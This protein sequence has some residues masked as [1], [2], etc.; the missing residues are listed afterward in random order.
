MLGAAYCSCGADLAGYP[1]WEA[2]T[3]LDP[4]W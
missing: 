2:G 4:A 1:L 3:G